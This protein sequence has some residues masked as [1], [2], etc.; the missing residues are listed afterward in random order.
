[1][2]VQLHFLHSYQAEYMEDDQHCLRD[3]VKLH[4]QDTDILTH[5]LTILVT[6]GWEKGE[7]GTQNSEETGVQI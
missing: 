7:D 1:M 5:S 2:M 3:G 6:Y 4:V